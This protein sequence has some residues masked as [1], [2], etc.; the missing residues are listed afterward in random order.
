[1]TLAPLA[2]S[3]LDSSSRQP[4]CSSAPIVLPSLRD[5]FPQYFGVTG[6]ATTSGPHRTPRPRQAASA[7][8]RSFTRRAASHASASESDAETANTTSPSPSPSPSPPLQHQALALARATSSRTKGK[9]RHAC[10]LC[11]RCF[12]RPSSLGTHMNTHTG[13][14]PFVCPHANCGR[15]FNVESNLRRHMRTWHGDVAGPGHTHTH[16]AGSTPDAAEFQR[17][18]LRDAHND[19]QMASFF[20]DS[21][22]AIAPVGELSPFLGMG[23]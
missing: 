10:E 21:H 7:S 3:N 14:T 5:L 18:R 22:I 8:P 12:N 17:L 19:N 6:T 1:M 13:A 23:P 9:G 15:R 16:A 4:S 2:P 20:V 11:G